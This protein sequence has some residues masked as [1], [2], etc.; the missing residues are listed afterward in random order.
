MWQKDTAPGS[1]LGKYT[2]EQALTYCENLVLGVY[3]DWRLPNRN[4]LQSLVDYSR[5]N[6]ATSFPNTVASLIL[7]TGRLLPMQPLL[8]MRGM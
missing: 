4:E 6:L 3:S 2:W 5:Y 1:Q 8:A 7:S